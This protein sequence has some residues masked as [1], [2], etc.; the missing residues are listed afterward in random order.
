MREQQLITSRIKPAGCR[1]KQNN[2]SAETPKQPQ[3]DLIQYDPES[4]SRDATR[5][6][7]KSQ[8]QTVLTTTT[9]TSTSKSDVQ[10]EDH[11]LQIIVA[12]ALVCDAQPRRLLSLE[13]P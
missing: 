12:K 7:P 10:N 4:C 3:T 6:Q 1:T 5:R 11:P 2:S 13:L 8:Q 9:T